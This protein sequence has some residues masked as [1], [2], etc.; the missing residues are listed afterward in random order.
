M[1]ETCRACKGRGKIHTVLPVPMNVRC[2]RCH[3]SGRAEDDE[4]VVPPIDNGIVILLELLW[5]RLF[6]KRKQKKRQRDLQ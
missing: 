1:Q 6:R 4:N 2:L 5:E 3:G